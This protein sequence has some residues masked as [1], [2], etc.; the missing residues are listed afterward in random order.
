M[1]THAY[2]HVLQLALCGGGC[3]RW[4]SMHGVWFLCVCV[5]IHIPPPHSAS[6]PSVRL[7]SAPVGGGKTPPAQV[8]MGETTAGASGALCQC[9]R[10]KHHHQKLLPVTTTANTCLMPLSDKNQLVTYTALFQ[11]MA[12]VDVPVLMLVNS[13]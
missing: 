3:M 8:A 5:C 11:Q 6:C 1:C 4:C 13:G 10:E 7:V 12:V 2:E 9:L